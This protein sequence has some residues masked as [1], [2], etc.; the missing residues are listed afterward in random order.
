MFV[1]RLSNSHEKFFMK[2]NIGRALHTAWE[3][4]RADWDL[5]LRV[6]G[7]FV[8]LPQFASLLLVPVAPIMPDGQPNEAAVRV[9]LDAF[10]GWFGTYGPWLFGAELLTLFGSLVMLTVYLGDPRPTLREALADS[11]RLFPRYFLAALLVSLPAGL[12]MLPTIGVVLVLPSLYLFG[13]LLLSGATIVAEQPIGAVP[14]LRRSVQLTRGN[15]MVM[16]AISGLLLFGGQLAA[17]PFV[18]AGRALGGAPMANP[19]AAALLD[20]MAAAALTVTVIVSVLVRISL[21]REALA[22]NRGM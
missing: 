7:L 2:I 21:Y 3:M 6:A 9:W 17:L 20:A 8:F 5:L 22:L 13:R 11:L 10:T 18:A 19:V 14:S 12:F 1:R 15:G 4:W 16:M